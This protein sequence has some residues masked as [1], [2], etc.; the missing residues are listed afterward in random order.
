MIVS[1]MG[2]GDLAELDDV[3]VAPVAGGGHHCPDALA[4]DQRTPAAG[5]ARRAV[6]ELAECRDR[7]GVV[8]VV[9]DDAIPVQLEHVQAP[10]RHKVAGGEVRSPWRASWRCAPA[11]HVAAAAASVLDIHPRPALE[12]GRQRWVQTSG[13]FLRPWR[14]TI[15]SPFRPGS[16]VTARRRAAGPA[17]DR[18]VVPVH[19]EVDDRSGAMA[20][21][22]GHQRIVGVEDRSAV[23]R[24]LPR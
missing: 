3:L 23:A 24:H 13:R 7:R 10:R 17:A 5:P 6:H 2:R 22:G 8:R 15:M 1:K 19:A 21:H 14:R 16:I 20:A 12:G 11:A 18:L 4:G 9:D